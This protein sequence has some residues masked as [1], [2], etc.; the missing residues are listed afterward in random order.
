MVCEFQ[1]NQ[2]F[3]CDL[4]IIHILILATQSDVG[5]MAMGGRIESV[6]DGM[7]ILIVF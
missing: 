2:S 7:W 3:Y 6:D 1:L 5:G 4:Y